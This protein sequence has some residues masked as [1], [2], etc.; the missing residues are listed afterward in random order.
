MDSKR[1]EA[2]LGVCAF[3]W[4]FTAACVEVGDGGGRM[5]GKESTQNM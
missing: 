1:N 3:V 4:L 2:K 5:K